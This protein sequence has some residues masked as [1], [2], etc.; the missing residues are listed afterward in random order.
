MHTQ[1]R[2]LGN[3]KKTE[4]TNMS[5]I[6]LTPS[7]PSQP[8][9]SSDAHFTVL[10]KCKRQWGDISLFNDSCLESQ[11]SPHTNCQSWIHLPAPR[12]FLS[13]SLRM[14]RLG[15]RHSLGDQKEDFRSSLALDPARH[16]EDQADPAGQ[17]G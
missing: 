7:S 11:A 3:L 8:M 4:S 1:Y 6:S 16:G 17:A 12:F 2:E 9:L 13:S 10:I 15:T 5:S 14:A